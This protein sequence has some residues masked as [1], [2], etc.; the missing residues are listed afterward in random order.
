M[1]NWS[2]LSLRRTLQMPVNKCHGFHKLMGMQK[3]NNNFFLKGLRWN[4]N[5][6]LSK[7]SLR[8]H[9]SESLTLNPITTLLEWNFFS[10]LNSLKTLRI[11]SLSFIIYNIP[12]QLA[13]VNSSVFWRHQYVMLVRIHTTSSKVKRDDI[14]GTCHSN[15][16]PM[17]AV[18]KMQKQKKVLCYHTNKHL[19]WIHVSWTYRKALYQLDRSPDR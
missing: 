12:D 10:S 8:N 11:I 19:K 6:E 13:C 15:D 3:Q 7:K 5:N 14:H 9:F 4:R 16:N 18:S 17:S 2:S 1:V